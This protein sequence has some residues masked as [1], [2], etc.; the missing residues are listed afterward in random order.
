[1]KAEMPDGPARIVVTDADRACG[2]ALAR[3]LEVEGYA[4]VPVSMGSAR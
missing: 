4:P 3:L 2:A 1:M